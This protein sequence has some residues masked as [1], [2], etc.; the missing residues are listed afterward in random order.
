MQP[1]VKTFLD[2]IAV[3]KQETNETVEKKKTCTYVLIKATYTMRAF[4][5]EDTESSRGVL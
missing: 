5:W 2:I 1:F 3:Y 4:A